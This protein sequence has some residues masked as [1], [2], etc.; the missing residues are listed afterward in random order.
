MKPDLSQTDPLEYNLATR[1]NIGDALSRAAALFPVRVAVVDGAD[2]ITYRQLDDAAERLARS[3]LDLGLAPQTPLTIMMGNSWRFLA[4]YYACAKAGLVA[5][6]VNYVLAP[7]DQRWI[8]EDAG[9]RAVVVDAQLLPLLDKVLDGPELIDTIIVSG[10]APARTG[11]H[12]YHSWQELAA[13][14]AGDGTRVGVLIEDRDAVQCI[15]TS[16][17]TSRP[18]GVL[19]SHVA[20]QIALLS[21]SLATRQ[22]Y[23]EQAPVMLVVL[24]LFHTTA[25][26]TLAMPVLGVGGTLVLSGPPFDPDAALDAIVNHGVTY[27]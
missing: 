19:V 27:L 16:G 26:N 4:T 18:K 11:G 12:S 8:L 21:N 15:Y 5:M 6:P 24:P 7:D 22:S 3:L 2:D 13:A 1:V 9:S 17:T 25:L 20:L 14:A 10:D 23:G